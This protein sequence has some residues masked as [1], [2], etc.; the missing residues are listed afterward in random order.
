VRAL[1]RY[2]SDILSAA[3][4][5]SSSLM[6]YKRS[7]QRYHTKVALIEMRALSDAEGVTNS[8]G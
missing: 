2:P 5:V 1:Q 8:K 4:R 7:K 3:C 6:Q